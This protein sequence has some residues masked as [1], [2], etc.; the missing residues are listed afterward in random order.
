MVTTRTPAA[1]ATLSAAAI[2]W[3]AIV[4]ASFLQTYTRTQGVAAF[5]AHPSLNAGAFFKPYYSLYS[6][7]RKYIS[8]RTVIADN[9]AGFVPFMLHADNI[10][11]LGICSR[12]YAELPT[13]DVIFTE[14]GR[15]QPLTPASPRRAGEAYLIYQDAQFLLVRRQLL[16]A[17]N[18]FEPRV[19]LGGYYELL[20]SDEQGDNAIFRRTGLPADAFQ[21][22][23]DA[24]LEDLAHVS[25][26]KSAAVDDVAIAP[27][28][29]LEA[30]PWLKNQA[31]YL[32]VKGKTRATVTFGSEDE[33]VR[34]ISV[35]GLAADAPATF[36]LFLKTAAGQ[37]VDHEQVCVDA[38]ETKSL[39]VRLPAGSYAS[40]MEVVV[41]S[42]PS[43][44]VVARLTDVR[45]LGQRPALQRYVTTHLEFPKPGPSTAPSLRTR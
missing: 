35:E 5:L 11:D 31:G 43:R 3:C 14:V 12:F 41:T 27:S 38:G 22:T 7:A 28:H 34:L 25:Y 32:R 37:E 8:P 39:S 9:Q 19:L 23:P 15:Y 45:V 44:D 21:T 2:A 30:L 20:D 40:S 24:F 16:R 13:T 4:G 26:V 36:D 6:L 42:D 29:L 33:P 18:S 1:G 10:D 17:A